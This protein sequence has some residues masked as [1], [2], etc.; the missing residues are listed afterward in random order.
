MAKIMAKCSPHAGR[1][2]TPGFGLGQKDTHDSGWCRSCCP[3]WVPWFRWPFVPD[4]NHVLN[5]V[6]SVPGVTN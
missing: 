3:P 4:K 5:Y 6:T 1:N 2:R